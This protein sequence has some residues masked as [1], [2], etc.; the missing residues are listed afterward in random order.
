MKLRIF[1]TLFTLL[2]LGLVTPALAQFRPERPDFYE[3][4]QRQLEREIQRLNQ[5]PP[6]DDVL[7]LEGEKVEWQQLNSK[8]GNFTVLMPGVAAEDTEVIETSAGTLQFKGW[9][10]EQ[11]ATKFF[12]AYAD[13]PSTAQLGNPEAL[14]ADLSAQLYPAAQEIARSER[15]LSVNGYPGRE[16]K[17]EQRGKRVTGRLFLVDRRL[18]ILLVGE[19]NPASSAD[20]VAKFLESFALLQ[21]P[22]SGG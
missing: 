22:A 2:T 12:V 3:D 15:P 5:K 11:P 16:D 1:S 21:K 17:L 9:S 13:Y 20:K 6:A 19:D 4:G 14:L 8:D 7:T 10:S 18:Y